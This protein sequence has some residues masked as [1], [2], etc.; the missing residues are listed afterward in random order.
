M[1]RYTVE[2]FNGTSKTFDVKSG[3]RLLIPGNATIIDKETIE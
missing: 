2:Y 3:E 1:I